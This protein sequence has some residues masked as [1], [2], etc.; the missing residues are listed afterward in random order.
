VKSHRTHV[1]EK[2]GVAN[3]TELAN[4]LRDT[5]VTL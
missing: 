4:I 5:G 1:F 2:L 3:A